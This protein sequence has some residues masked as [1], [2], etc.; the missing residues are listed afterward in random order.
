M[1]V[2]SLPGGLGGGPGGRCVVVRGTLCRDVELQVQTDAT[3][4]GRSGG[5]VDRL[6]TYLG[7]SSGEETMLTV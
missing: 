5:A 1:Q 4:G 2:G 7:E 3:L 6:P